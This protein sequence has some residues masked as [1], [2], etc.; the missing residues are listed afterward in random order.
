MDARQD[1]DDVNPTGAKRTSEVRDVEKWTDYAR[2]KA[3]RFRN[4]RLELYVN[5][6]AGRLDLFTGEEAP[7]D[8]PEASAA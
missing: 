1:N 6:A 3:D 5:R 7:E 2:A 4:A 8:P